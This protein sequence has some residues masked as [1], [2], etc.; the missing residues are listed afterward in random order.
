MSLDLWRFVFAF[1]K[2]LW[3]LG[4]PTQNIAQPL[5]HLTLWLC[6][7]RPATLSLV[8]S[9]TSDWQLS[10]PSPQAT[11]LFTTLTY[12]TSMGGWRELLVERVQRVPIR[13]LL[14]QNK[15]K[16]R[17][18]QR[19]PGGVCAP[20]CLPAGAPVRLCLH[21]RPEGT[22]RGGRRVSQVGRLQGLDLQS[23]PVSTVGS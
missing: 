15:C 7:C 6:P 12:G 13:A 18:E 3:V 1:R 9:A 19:R 16:M 8:H 20:A 5:T 4:V 10:L 22:L 17:G 2:A 23:L 11:C 21:T 14:K